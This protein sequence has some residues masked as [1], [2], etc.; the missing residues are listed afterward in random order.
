MEANPTKYVW[1][2]NTTNGWQSV[3]G[4]KKVQVLN[5]CN[6]TL[7][8][9]DTWKYLPPSVRSTCMYASTTNRPRLL[10]IACNRKPHSINEWNRTSKKLPASDNNKNTCSGAS[11]CA[12]T[13]TGLPFDVT[14]SLISHFGLVCYLGNL[15]ATDSSS[16]GM[17]KP[18]LC[19]YILVTRAYAHAH[20]AFPYCFRAFAFAFWFR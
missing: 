1:E 13:P 4:S 5:V 3:G 19:M 7:I 15:Q 10:Y 2:R 6:S 11:A 14:I 20:L 18:V 17:S 16:A 9:K 8:P 12:P